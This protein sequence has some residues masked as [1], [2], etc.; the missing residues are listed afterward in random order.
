MSLTS[1]RAT[2]FALAAAA[3]ASLL[4]GSAATAYG[5]PVIHD[6][7]EFA[8]ETTYGAGE[9]C[10]AAVHERIEGRFHATDLAGDGG[11]IERVRV[12][13]TYT[14]M[15]T[16]ARATDSGSFTVRAGS[17]TL[18]IAGLTVNL[19]ESDGT[20]HAIDAGRV[21]LDAETF[22][23]ISRSGQVLD[24]YDAAVCGALGSTPAG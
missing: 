4:G 2:R 7:G 8:G 21:V 16:G 18:T 3:A 20:L 19:R 22:E 9:L 1:P 12:V 23:V 15:Q 17:G 24:D 11:A 6:R 13:F 10:D 14:N 5:A